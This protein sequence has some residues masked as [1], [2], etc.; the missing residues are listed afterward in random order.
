MNIVLVGYDYP[1]RICTAGYTHPTRVFD[2]VPPRYS[3][4]G[5]LYPPLYVGGYTYHDGVF[6]PGGTRSLGCVYPTRICTGW[7]THR[8]RVFDRVHPREHIPWVFVPPIICWGYTY[9]DRVFVL[10]GT[11]SLGCVY[12]PRICTGGVHTPYPCV[13]SC[14]PRYTYPG[15]ACVPP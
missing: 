5:C 6:V 10:R 4:V 7:Y 11:R 12:P 3:S 8:T 14:T 1:P 13:R 2:R 9:P 15:R